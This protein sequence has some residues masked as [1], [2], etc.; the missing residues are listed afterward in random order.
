MNKTLSRFFACILIACLPLMIASCGGGSGGAGGAGGAGPT[1]ILTVTALKGPIGGALI[2]VFQLLPD[3]RAG[4]LLGSGVSDGTGS[5]TFDIPAAKLAGPVL[6]KVTGQAGASYTS[7]TTGLQVPFKAGE[8][9]NAVTG[10]VSPGEKITVSPLTEAAYQQLQKILTATPSLAN[11]LKIGGAINAANNRI[12]TLFGTSSILADP[13]SDSS[14]TY[15]AALNV[16]DQMIVSAKSDTFAVMNS[17]NQ[18][19]SNAN[20]N[21]PV[22]QS[23]RQALIA[24]ANSVAVAKPEFAAALQVITT[25]ANNPPAEPAWTDASAPTAPTN[26][27][28]TPTAITSNTSSVRLSWDASADNIAVSGYDIYRDDIKVASVTI[29]AYTDPSL[30]NNSTYKYYVLAFDAVGNRSVASNQIFVPLGLQAVDITPPTAPSNLSAATFLTDSSSSVVLMWNPATDNKAVTGYDVYRDNVKITSVAAPG[31]TDPQ[32]VQSATYRYYIVAFDGAGNRSAAS[33]QLSVTPNSPSLGV[34]VNGQLSLGVI[35]LPRTDLVSPT[36]PSGLVASTFA[37]SATASSVVL[38]W[39]LS[40][41]N[42]AV[43]GYE[44]YRGG[45]RIA[46]VTLPGYTDPS[47]TSAVTYTYFI[48]AFDAA[49]NRSIAS[50]QLLVTPNQATLGVLVNGQLSP[51]VI[52]QPSLDTIAP[53]APSGLTASTSAI[54]AN[55]SSVLLAWRAASDN[56]AVAGYEVYRNGSR[57]ATVPLLGYT[58]PSVTATVTYTYY[59]IAI[60]AAGNR[61][62]ASNQLLVTPNQASLGVTVSG[63]LASGVV[64]QPLQDVTPPT[65]TPNLTASTS[66]VSAT[67]SAVLLA[68]SPSVDNTAVTGYDVYRNGSRIATVT[69]LGYLDSSVPSGSTSNYY[70]VAFDAAG[71]RSAPSS[72]LPVMPGLASLGVTVNGQLSSTL[73]SLPLLDTAAASF[74]IMS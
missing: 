27:S 15:T 65:A 11:E 7:E 57:I 69:M 62:V 4:D 73:I 13:A 25:L 60:D 49:G 6:V 67:T 31:Y 10:A 23:Y 40:T 70:V 34:T 3:G 74:S 44:I 29:P 66:A 54:T 72:T 53:S 50:N 5:Y 22:Y 48:V 64:G 39:N 45:S 33:N 18:A 59:I 36:A 14:K 52:G 12:A 42:T 38:S 68:W 17:I 51:G 8:S 9:F 56:T 30:A 26:L 58:D 61:S 43:A 32:V 47:V 24:A 21:N 20:T 16:I 37:Q 41:D 63:Q 35:G 46:T 71:N 55:S 28:A 2:Q 1:S 19:L